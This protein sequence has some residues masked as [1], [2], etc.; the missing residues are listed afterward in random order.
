MKPIFH[1]WLAPLYSRWNLG[2][3]KSLL[4]WISILPLLGLLIG[5]AIVL[6][7]DG[8]KSW[9][10]I[11]AA[12]AIGVALILGM[13]VF[14]WAI[15]LILNIGTQ[16]SPINAHLVPGFTRHLKRALAIP[17]LLLPVIPYLVLGFAKSYWVPSLWFLFVLVLLGYTCSIR[18][19]WLLLIPIVMMFQLDRLLHLHSVFLSQW[20]NTSLFLYSVLLVLAGFVI[21]YTMLTWAFAFRGDPLFKSANAYRGRFSSINGAQLG[22]GRFMFPQFFFASFQRV[23]TRGDV[24]SRALAFS[25]GPNAHWSRH[26]PIIFLMSLLL[27]PLSMVYQ[28]HSSNRDTNDILLLLFC[29]MTYVLLPCATVY[30]IHQAI[31]RNQNAQKVVSLTS[32]AGSSLDQ[33]RYLLRYLLLQFL[34]VWFASLCVFSILSFVFSFSTM[35][36]IPTVLGIFSILP[37]AASLIKNHAS[38]K[39]SSDSHL[40]SW[41]FVC[42]FGFAMASFLQWHLP[43]TVVWPWCALLL[44]LSGVLLYLRWEIVKK[45]PVIFP[46]GRAC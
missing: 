32:F 12:F 16:F 1:I 43:S 11:P 29:F 14:F 20:S 34:I 37:M 6:A 27:W 5:I 42:I 26:I 31:Y 22:N 3:K 8:K 10:I 15:L 13:L 33:T 19:R 25:V 9:I 36:V 41:F 28:R 24:A 2:D 35:V 46:V 18:V 30:G 4:V 17:V 23:F 44:F 21:T 45:V 40:F 38:T 7:G 39:S